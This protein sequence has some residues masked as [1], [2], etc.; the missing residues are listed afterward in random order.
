MKVE[1]PLEHQREDADLAQKSASEEME[2]PYMN[3][4]ANEELH[5][6]NPDGQGEFDDQEDEQDDTSIN[7]DLYNSIMQSIGKVWPEFNQA[8]GVIGE[9]EFPDVMI[10][11]AADQN[12]LDEEAQDEQQLQQ[13]KMFFTKEN[14]VNIF[15]QIQSQEQ[16]SPEGEQN[17][18]QY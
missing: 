16:E 2:S 15:Q 7:E 3:P 4:D 6:G 10:R 8:D 12:L 14:L 18:E 17:G 11:I 1:Q 5:E 9:Q 13:N